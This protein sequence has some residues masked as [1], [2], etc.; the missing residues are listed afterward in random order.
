MLKKRILRRTALQRVAVSTISC[1][2]A[3]VLAN[4][5]RRSLGESPSQGKPTITVLLDEA[6]GT[7]KPALYGHFTEHIGG[8]I[9]DGIWV[10]R[11]SK[12]PNIDGIR[13]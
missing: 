10:G 8:V 13:Q 12:I 6:I 5:P 1:V 9:Y 7:I 2:G 4:A 11:D 3:T